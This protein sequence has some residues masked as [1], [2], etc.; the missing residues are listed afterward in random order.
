[1]G[2]KVHDI[3]IAVPNLQQAAEFFQHVF[4][5]CSA[6]VESDE[7]KNLYIDFENFTLHTMEDPGR[8]RGEPFGRLDHI[9][10][11]VDDLDETTERLAERGVTMAWEKP[12]RAARYRSNFTNEDGGVGVVFQLADEH[13]DDREWLE[14]KPGMMESLAR[15][16]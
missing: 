12:V 11:M 6:R 9:A 8:L 3:G 16:S 1:M 7:V 14:F 15:K 5:V 2:S 13:V 10:V 4:G